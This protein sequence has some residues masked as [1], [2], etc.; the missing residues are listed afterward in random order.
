MKI[1][2]VEIGIGELEELLVGIDRLDTILTAARYARPITSVWYG[3][4]L[5]CVYA[6][7]PATMLSDDAY[8]WMHW[9][10]AVAKHK[11][12][13]AR[14]ARSLVQEILERYPTIIGHCDNA[15]SVRWLKSLGASFG[16]APP[17]FA[18]FRISK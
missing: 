6:L 2:F 11:L 5:L 8:I 15:V 3:E 1:E 14:R 12:I 9:T 10:A 7:I 17:P 16:P 13:F 18:E 4:D